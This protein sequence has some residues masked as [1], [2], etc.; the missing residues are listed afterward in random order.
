MTPDPDSAV[1][2]IVARV[3]AR[4]GPRG[5]LTGPYIEELAQALAA[6]IEYKFPGMF[7]RGE[8]VKMGRRVCIEQQAQRHAAGSA[9]DV[10]AQDNPLDKALLA[11]AC[12]LAL[13]AMTQDPPVVRDW[14]TSDAAL[15]AKHFHE[16]GREAVI[17]G[18]RKLKRRHLF[19]ESQ[20]VQCYLILAEELGREPALWETATEVGV[21][22]ETVAGALLLFKNM[23]SQA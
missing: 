14:A 1:T 15:V 7:S 18:L 3:K 21:D 8:R 4:P 16:A 22:R 13:D 10:R 12:D 23:L 2:A 19:V 20:I 9:V 5:G 17:A 11:A 6:H